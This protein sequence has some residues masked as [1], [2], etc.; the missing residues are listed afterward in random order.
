[1]EYLS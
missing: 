1:M